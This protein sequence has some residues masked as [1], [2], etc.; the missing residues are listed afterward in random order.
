MTD[1][2]LEHE[3]I[4]RLSKVAWGAVRA[5]QRRADGDT[6]SLL[7][8]ATALAHAAGVAAKA[9]A[10]FHP[11]VNEITLVN[12]VL[13]QTGPYRLIRLAS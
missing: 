13:S 1:V 4:H 8:I 6:V 5:D 12:S 3:E 2:I 11:G 10:R 9:V 7:L